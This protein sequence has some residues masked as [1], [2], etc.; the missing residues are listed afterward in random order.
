MKNIIGG[1]ATEELVELKLK[2][3]YFLVDNGLHKD[4][5]SLNREIN[6]TK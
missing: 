4:A 3:Y 1:L 6:I 5:K 2:M